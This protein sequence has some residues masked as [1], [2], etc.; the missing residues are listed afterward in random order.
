MGTLIYIIVLNWN[1]LPDTVECVESCRTLTY[2]RFRLV[3]VDNGST[4]GSASVV[5]KRFPDVEVIETGCN[6]GFAGGN[7]VGIR[8]ALE[9]GADC[10]W[11]LNN[12][13]VVE[14][15]TLSALVAVMEGDRKAGMVGSKIR[16]FDARDRLWYAGAFLDGRVPY[17]CGHRGLNEEDLGQY[18]DAGETG[19]VTGCSLLVRR[20]LIEQIGLL[21]EGLFLYFEDTDWGARAR[22]S[23]WK[24][25]YAPQSLVLHKASATMGGM[26]SPRMRYYLARNLLY[27]VR[28]NYP[29]ALFRAFGFDLAQNVVVMAK[30]GRLSAA[31]WALRGMVDFLRGRTG[32]L[33]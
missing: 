17:R 4:D 28:K 27:F 31:G 3:I 26:E 14:P 33:L 32:P 8:H 29:D 18:D 30:K 23:G 11:L 16:Y 10:I 19:Y 20:E 5:R 25:L 15:D 24:L 13:T 2:S 9:N 22:S 7:N 1:G 6:L 12:D 21:D